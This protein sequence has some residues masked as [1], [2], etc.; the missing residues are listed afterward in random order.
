MLF[1]ASSAVT[2]GL[3]A[4]TPQREIMWNMGLFTHI[5]MYALMVVAF[6]IFG[7]G[8]R[9]RIRF[10]KMGKPDGERAGDW[11]KRFWILIRETFFQNQARN[12]PLPAVFH[13]MIFY[14]FVML[15][16]A[17]LVVMADM[18]FGIDIFHGTFYLVISL[19]A[20]LAG[21]FLLVGLAI[22][23]V[24]RYLSKP[25]FLP[26]TKPI[27]TWVLG[28]LA[29][30]ALTGFLAEG[31]R[32]AHHPQGDPWRAYTP[33][34][35]AFAVLV[36]GMSQGAGRALHFGVWWIH[37]LGT[38]AMIA[39]IPYTKFFHMLSIPTNQ[40]LR[41]LEPKG[42]LTRVD[43]EELFASD[44]MDEEFTLGVSQGHHLNWKQRLDLDACIHCGR[45]DEI[46]PA[47]SVDQPLSPRR[48]I[49]DIKEICETAYAARLKSKSASAGASEGEG[50]GQTSAGQGQAG[51]GQGQA[52]AGQ[53]LAEN[54]AA[55]AI[56]GHEG[57]VFED[58]EFIWHCRTCHACQTVC[59]AAIEHVDL[60]VE[61]RR[62]EVMMEGRLPT[63]AGKALKTMETQG[64]PFGSQAERMDL[65][66]KLEIPVLKEGEET[67]VLFWIGCATTFDPQKHRI[68]EDMVA[69]MRAAG[70][71]FAHLGKDEG[72][73]GDPAR[74]LG[75]EN[76]FQMT[77]KTTVE[78]LKS[79]TFRHLLVLCPHGYNV[80]KNE[81]PQFGAQLP[82]VHHSELLADWIREG[83]IKLEKPAAQTVTFHDPCYLGRY[84]GIF[85]PP[86]EV[87]RA[88]PGI[89][90]R[91][92]ASHHERSFCCGAGG[93]HFWMDIDKGD[94]R[95]YTHRVD[96]AQ[97]VGADVIAVGCAFC[98]QMLLDG[99]KARDL[100]EKIVIKDIA[101]LVRESI[102]S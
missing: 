85:D 75:D 84:Q 47:W 36:G 14:S 69:I 43:I 81:Y 34:G 101:S 7:I 80:F 70:I 102:G 8:L 5:A 31:A 100:D 76:L 33:I 98:Y 13:S 61:L 37:A 23:A 68:A 11:G 63:D 46:C 56:L 19:L 29:F 77:A 60:F 39:M 57:T 78:A 30:L 9:R 87:L 10:W 51:A 16:I 97:T 59:P 83:R 90:L 62:S 54:D 41:K 42:A 99:T 88:I 92:M 15:F 65:V 40:F 32:I 35:S 22:A 44:D 86:R 4:T 48:L 20:D 96:E 93:G 82:V 50:E 55:C 89:K 67:E 28:I 74:V 73:C 58:P 25:K 94:G 27:D 18:D 24:R 45:C 64:N 26:E 21:G 66:E 71:A 3:A 17:T 1:V 95:T 52:G 6:V 38:F 2:E 12:R 72:C 91:E 79:R 49:E 53:G